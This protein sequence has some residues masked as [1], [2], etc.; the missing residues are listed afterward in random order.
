MDVELVFAFIHLFNESYSHKKPKI[1]YSFQ[2]QLLIL[3]C[4]STVYFLGCTEVS[5]MFLVIIDLAKFFP[6]E[7]N[8]RF[9]TVV[10]VSGPPFAVTF[11]FYRVGMWWKVS[12]M[13]FRDCHAVLST[14][15]SNQLRPGKDYVLYVFL[16]LNI[17]L[18]CLQLYWF[19]II[20]EEAMKLLSG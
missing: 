20:L 3:P 12:Y 14:G 15:R 8:T 16:V 2:Q 9:D 4:V 17:P 10:A 1:S 13:L 19:S 18:G 5:S 7:P 6:P 11:A